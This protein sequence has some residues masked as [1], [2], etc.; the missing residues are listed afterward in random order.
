MTTDSID[1]DSEAWELMMCLVHGHAGM[2]RSRTV[3]TETGARDVNRLVQKGGPPPYQ[4]E[5]KGGLR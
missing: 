5:R 1:R 3:R 4:S 2:A